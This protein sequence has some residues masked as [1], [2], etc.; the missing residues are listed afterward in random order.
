MLQEDFSSRAIASKVKVCHKTVCRIR[1]QAL[2]KLVTSRGGRKESLTPRDR[3]VLVRTLTVGEAENASELRDSLQRTR[4][5]L[6]STETIRTALKK[7]GMKAAVKTKKPIL[8]P[9]HKKARLRFA[10]AH[11]E[12]TTADWARI[13]WSDETKINRLGSDG[14]KWVWKRPSRSL[15]PRAVQQTLKFGGGSLMVWGCMCSQGV[16]LLSRIEG[17]MNAEIYTQ[18][19]GCELIQTLERYGLARRDVVFQQDNDPKHTLTQTIEP[20]FSSRSQ[21][22]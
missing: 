18:I 6:V 14:R 16:G 15:D 3:R 9:Q 20:M 4:G 5:V 1:S 21:K 19:L 13:I 17:R 2:P 7:E 11:K 10:N 12:W 22:C 8:K